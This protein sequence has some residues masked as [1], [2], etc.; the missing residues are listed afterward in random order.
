MGKYAVF[1]LFVECGDTKRFNVFLRSEAELLFY[2]KLN[3]ESVRVPA[4]ATWHMVALHS[5]IARDHVFKCAGLKVVE[6]R[7]CICCRRSFKKDKLAFW[8]IL[9]Q[10]LFKNV[11]L[12]PKRQHRFFAKCQRRVY[13]VGFVC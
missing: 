3:G 5:F 7:F 4:G 8:R 1:T 11:V 9:L 13:V 10:G 12:F 2:L 6:R